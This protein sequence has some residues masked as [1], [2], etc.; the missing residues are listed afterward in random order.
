MDPLH[1]DIHMRHIYTVG[2]NLSLKDSLKNLNYPVFFFEIHSSTWHKHLHDVITT[3]YTIVLYC[4]AV[5]LFVDEYFWRSRGCVSIQTARKICGRIGFVGAKGVQAGKGTSA[6]SWNLRKEYVHFAEDGFREKQSSRSLLH[7]KSTV[8]RQRTERLKR[9]YYSAWDMCVYTCACTQESIPTF[10]SCIPRFC[11]GTQTELEET[12]ERWRKREREIN[13][14][15]E[16]EGRIRGR[17]T[18]RRFDCTVE[19]LHSNYLQ[20]SMGFFPL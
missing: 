17:R 9:R 15:R 3:L 13:R 20:T 6:L 4:L 2:W 1:R 14:R 5:C 7:T 12:I 19:A 11:S 18:S 16:E 10:P 8:V